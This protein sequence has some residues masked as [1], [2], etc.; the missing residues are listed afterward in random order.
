MCNPQVRPFVLVDIAAIAG[1]VANKDS[2]EG[3]VQNSNK[4]GFG[5]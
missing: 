1:G 5:Q 3:A 2:A 4:S